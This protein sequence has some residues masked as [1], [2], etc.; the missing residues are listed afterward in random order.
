M[1]S[2]MAAMVTRHE[3]TIE[4]ALTY[5][6]EDP[7][8]SALVEHLN[9][10]RFR[11]TLHGNTPTERAKALDSLKATRQASPAQVSLMR[12]A[13]AAAA[14]RAPAAI[15]DRVRRLRVSRLLDRLLPR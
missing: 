10:I 14:V 11:V 8:R 2:N 9:R 6:A 1:S 12:Y 5:I 13:M 3:R 7:Y 15:R 4:K